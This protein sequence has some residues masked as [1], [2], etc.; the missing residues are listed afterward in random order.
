M[1]L[2]QLKVFKSGK[3]VT[4]EKKVRKDCRIF[5]DEELNRMI[6]E[7]IGQVRLKGHAELI[8]PARLHP[9]RPDSLTKNAQAVMETL[10]Q[11]GFH[12]YLCGGTVRDLIR[13]ETVNDFDFVTDASNE[14]LAELFSG[15]CFHEIPAGHRFGYLDFGNEIIDV[16][17]FV[18]IPARYRGL[19]NVPE[20]DP[21][22]LYSSRLLFDAYQ[23]DFTCNSMYYDP[24]SGDLISYFGG[25]YSLREGIIMT[26]VDAAAVF[27]YDPRRAMRALRFS[28]RFGFT[29]AEDVE[30]A[31]RELGAECV[32]RI[33]P[34]GMA[35]NLPDFFSGGFARDG[36]ERLLDYHLFWDLFPS[37]RDKAGNEEY[38]KYVLRTARAADWLFDEGTWALPMI[39]M[40]A[41]LW[42]AVR[43]ARDAGAD[44]PVEQVL[45]SQ[46][47][48]LRMSGKDEDYFRGTLMIGD[49]DPD[50]D[51]IR[52]EVS[53]IF[54][55]PEFKDGLRMLR[56]HYLANSRK[57]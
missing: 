32:R 55:Q 8:V 48:I 49:A 18:N 54:D 52:E 16:A 1:K 12:A 46:K 22:A 57:L 7:N 45:R 25:L 28:S 47:E 41:F 10:H 30:A 24:A 35:E 36:T 20:S 56:L 26:P 13:E 14:Q 51:R 21:E 19:P 37:V 29:L 34:A 17:T 2:T 43:D 53:E 33:D 15:I 38:R 6:D 23:R 27:D 4:L 42:P 3:P 39:V 5:T 31:V 11:A 9:I 50:R 44:N 40:A